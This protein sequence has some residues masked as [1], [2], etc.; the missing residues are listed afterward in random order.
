M[1]TV[2]ITILRAHDADVVRPGLAFA[3]LNQCWTPSVA[4]FRR[5][6]LFRER[7]HSRNG[8]RDRAYEIRSGK[9]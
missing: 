6:G 2:S 8:Y 9:V 7:I 3:F 4:R 1:R 5:S